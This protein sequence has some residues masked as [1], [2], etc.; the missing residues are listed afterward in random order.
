MTI[1]LAKVGAGMP[2]FE[3]LTII[4]ANLIHRYLFVGDGF[5]KCHS[6]LLLKGLAVIDAV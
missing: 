6:S 5:E 1:Y 4:R 2:E 3:A